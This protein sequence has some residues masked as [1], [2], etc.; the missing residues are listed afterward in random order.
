MSVAELGVM[1]AMAAAISGP[2][3]TVFVWWASRIDNKLDVL[4]HDVSDLKITTA[5][6]QT[7]VATLKTDMARTRKDIDWLR[8]QM[9][10][11]ES[12]S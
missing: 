11:D 1:A 3:V 6:L 2:M 4:T 10:P 5:V 12:A 8:S 7:D 9:P